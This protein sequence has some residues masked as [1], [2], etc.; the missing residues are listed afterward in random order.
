MPGLQRQ[1][2]TNVTWLTSVSESDGP[3]VG[4]VCLSDCWLPP[5]RH[6]SCSQRD[7]VVQFEPRCL[8][9]HTTRS[10]RQSAR[11]SRRSSLPAAGEHHP[12][13]LNNQSHDRV[14]ASKGKTADCHTPYAKDTRS[15]NRRQKTG[16][17]F[18]R[19]FF[20]PVAK[21]LAPETNIITVLLVGWFMYIDVRSYLLTVTV[22]LFLFTRWQ[23]CYC[24]SNTPLKWHQSRVIN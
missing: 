8:C 14:K 13:L 9:S 15:R 16:V 1:Y 21:F 23:Q 18:W 19:R 17:R 20:T 12:A 2:P 10:T 11:D 6:A 22:K 24:I 4:L 7:V 3:E 5:A